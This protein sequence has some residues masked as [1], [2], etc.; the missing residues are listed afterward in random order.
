MPK[1]KKD[2]EE[3][4]ILIEKSPFAS[5]SS[6]S[7]RYQSQLNF[8]KRDEGGLLPIDYIF[9]EDEPNKIDW[10]KMVPKKFIVPNRDKFPKDTN[11]K[12]LDINTIDDSKLLILLGGFRYLSSLRGYNY[13]K[14]SIDF[15]YPDFVAMTCEIEVI[16]NLETSMQSKIF[17]GEADAHTRNTHSFAA[18][19]L[20][21]IAG[22]RAFVRAWRNALEIPVLGFDE[23]GPNSNLENTSNPEVAS[24]AG[25]PHAALLKKIQEKGRSFEQLKK[26]LIKT[27]SDFLRENDLT[28]EVVLAWQDES[29]ISIPVVIKILGILSIQKNE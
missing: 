27:Q 7:Y 16:P 28:D 22:N 26:Y 6:D 13:I 11:F 29:N 15:A 5:P 2:I 4:N 21:C 3:P 19:Y 18:N 12:S 23:I 1:L 8:W 9:K 10:Y 25:G 14:Q 20:T 24:K 17:V